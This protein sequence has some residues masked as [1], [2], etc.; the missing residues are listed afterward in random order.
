MNLAFFPKRVGPVDFAGIKR[1]L[2]HNRRAIVSLAI[3]VFVFSF[4][5]YQYLE[6]IVE[7]A[8][9]IAA[10]FPELFH[11]WQQWI[12]E[13]PEPTKILLGHPMYYW[14]RLGKIFELGALVVIIVDLVG[15]ERLRALGASFGVYNA[16]EVYKRV[17]NKYSVPIFV[18][19]SVAY[20]I[21]IVVALE[22]IR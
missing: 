16:S 12:T 21:L 8:L 18:L 20:T 5:V 2:W 11:A 4:L 13:P 1:A 19:C 3:A 15:P 17:A 10:V 6:S 22:P 7:Q 14:S 9:S